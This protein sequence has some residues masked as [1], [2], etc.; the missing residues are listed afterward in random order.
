MNDIFVDDAKVKQ[1]YH[2]QYYVIVKFFKTKKNSF[3]S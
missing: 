1:I 2:G 3:F